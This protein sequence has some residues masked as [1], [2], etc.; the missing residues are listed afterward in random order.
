M[1]DRKPYRFKEYRRVGRCNQCGLCCELALSYRWT[2]KGNCK[3]MKIFG[4]SSGICSE[5]SPKDR[6]CLCHDNLPYFCKYFPENPSQLKEFNRLLRMLKI[7]RDGKQ[8]R[9]S[10][11]FVR[12]DN[13]K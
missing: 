13:G 7:K 10:Y 4:V 12:R 6:S 8:V 2:K 5:Y 11:R 3:D 1:K 9:C